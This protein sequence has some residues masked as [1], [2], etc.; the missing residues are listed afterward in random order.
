MTYTSLSDYAEACYKASERKAPIMM[1]RKQALAILKNHRADLTDF[2]DTAG[3][4]P[5]FERVNGARVFDYL[6]Y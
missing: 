1:P 4:C 2:Y 3:V 6:G 5:A